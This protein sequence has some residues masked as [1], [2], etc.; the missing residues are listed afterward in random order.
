MP[1]SNSDH[2]DRSRNIYSGEEI[3]HSESISKLPP[4]HAIKHEDVMLEIRFDLVERYG[5]PDGI[6]L[7]LC[8]GNG[9]HIISLSGVGRGIGLDFS[10]PFLKKGNALKKAAQD[11]RA[12]FVCADASQVPLASNSFD[13][14]YSFTSLYQVPHVEQVILDIA[15]ILKP[16]GICILELGNLHSLNKFVCDVYPE[17]PQ[18]QFIPV[19]Q[20]K[21]FVRQANL[22]V[23]EH[24]SFQVLPLWSNR[25]HWMGPLL[26]PGWND[27][28]SKQVG[29]RMLDEWISS[30]PLLRLFAFRHIFICSKV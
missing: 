13:L 3:Y 6:V 22:K 16:E 11:D 17:Y 25:P 29:G 20:M 18:S 9:Q 15:H 21:H 14:V 30:L 27:L 5:S 28:L 23:I 1:E 26:W 2:S 12:A 4:E 7:D 10:L 8:C 24:R 19:A